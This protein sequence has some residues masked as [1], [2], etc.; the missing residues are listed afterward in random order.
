[1]GEL[2]SSE[3]SATAGTFGHGS[4]GRFEEVPD[5]FELF[6]GSGIDD[7]KEDEESHHGGDEVGV[8]DFPHGGVSI[9]YGYF[10]FADEDEVCHDIYGK[11]GRIGEEG[12][13]VEEGNGGGRIAFLFC[14][15][16]ADVVILERI[17]VDGES[18]GECVGESFDA[19]DAFFW[20]SE[21]EEPIES[22][23]GSL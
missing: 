11:L 18:Y 16:E 4:V 10:L 17:Y 14:E 19:D 8:S 3:E 7:P 5:A 15:E 2:A 9:F 22:G 21:E 1:M 20:E 12:S 13:S 6:I 23:E